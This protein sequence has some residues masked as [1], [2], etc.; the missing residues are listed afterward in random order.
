LWRTFDGVV[1]DLNRAATGTDLLDVAS[2]YEA[3]ATIAGK[4]AVSVERDDRESGLRPRVRA[5][6]SA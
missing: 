2:A 4:L 3:L 5:R 6:R 1:A